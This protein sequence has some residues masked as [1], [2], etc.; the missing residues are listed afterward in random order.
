MKYLLYLSALTYYQSVNLTKF[1]E[2]IEYGA[3]IMNSASFQEQ[4]KN[5]LK[6]ENYS[7]ISLYLDNDTTGQKVKA[8]FD[9]E[10]QGIIEY[11]SR[12]YNNHKDFNLF[13]IA[14]KKIIN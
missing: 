5:A 4:T 11:C 7:K 3:I 2:L 10:F 1:Q 9:N 14:S 6:E 13:L 12:I 8:F